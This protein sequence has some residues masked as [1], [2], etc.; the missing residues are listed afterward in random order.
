MRIYLE[1]C[2]AMP[3]SSLPAASSSPS[4]RRQRQAVGPRWP[5]VKSAGQLSNPLLLK[6]ACTHPVCSSSTRLSWR[7]VLQRSAV[8]RLRLRVC[9]TACEPLHPST[10]HNPSGFLVTIASKPRAPKRP[11]KH[12]V[13]LHHDFWFPPS[14]GPWN[15]AVRSLCFCGVLGP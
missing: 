1:Y 10:Q 6:V 2:N 3:C 7:G 5:A 15:Q 9:T 11:H 14:I 8:R 4:F 12:V 13:I